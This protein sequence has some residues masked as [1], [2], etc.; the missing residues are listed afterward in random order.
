[1][2]EKLRAGGMG[3]GG[4]YTTAGIDTLVESGGIPIKYYK[5][6]DKVEEY[7]KPK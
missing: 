3:I 6:S 1:L 7:S 4:F 5:N 2:A